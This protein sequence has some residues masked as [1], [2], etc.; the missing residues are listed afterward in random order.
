MGS[1]IDPVRSS[2]NDGSLTLHDNS[3]S[4]PVHASV[5]HTTA[6]VDALYD[7]AY[8]IQQQGIH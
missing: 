6:V 3:G 7:S 4:R 2:F 8:V 1:D 5:I